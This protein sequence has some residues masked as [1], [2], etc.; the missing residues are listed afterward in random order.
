MSEAV[1][2]DGAVFVR[3]GVAEVIEDEVMPAA[4]VVSVLD[5]AMQFAEVALSFGLQLL[6]VNREFF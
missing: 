1:V 4:A 6:K 3:L 5:D 2:A